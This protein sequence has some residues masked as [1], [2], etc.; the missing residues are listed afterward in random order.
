[1]AEALAAG[2]FGQHPLGAPAAVWNH[3]IAEFTDTLSRDGHPM[4]QEPEGFFAAAR[5]LLA[6]IA[7]LAAGQRG[8][9]A[10]PAEMF[11]EKTPHNLLAIGFLAR[12]A[13]GARFL[14]V[15]RDPRS[16]AW[17]LLAMRWGPNE[18]NTAARWVDSYC[19]AW[20][21]A[22]ALAA[23]MG[24]HLIRLHIEEAA[25]A[26]SDAAAWLTARL[27]LAPHAGLLNG[28]DANLLNR[29]TAK[30]SVAERALL[31]DRLGGWAAH[32][33]YDPDCIG[34][35]PGPALYTAKTQSSPE[36]PKEPPEPHAG[37]GGSQVPAATAPETA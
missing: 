13:P 32:F 33:G 31:D 21:R 6:R 26:P 17:S 37:P 22:E 12:L 4:P 3:A 18:L 25:A 16:I 35:R 23:S 24:L 15:M 30:A 19:L 34:W 14:H 5:A 9:E 28:A 11:L 20:V 8:S 36:T 27:D 2:R 29:W 7:A 1:M 10:P